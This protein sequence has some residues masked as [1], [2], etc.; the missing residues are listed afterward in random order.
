M[1]PCSLSITNLKT[2]C[3]ITNCAYENGSTAF[4]L[5]IIRVW[6]QKFRINQRFRWK[7]YRK[8]IFQLLS[9]SS[10]YLVL[11]FPPMILLCFYSSGLSSSIG[12]EFYSA[13]LYLSY[14]ITLLLPLVS[15]FS[16]PDIHKKF[17]DIFSFHQQTNRVSPLNIPIPK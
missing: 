11:L 17:M 7:K 6:F 16:L 14:L 1:L 2:R 15:T 13:S 12:A 5:L 10:I 3:G 4:L 8:M 9:I